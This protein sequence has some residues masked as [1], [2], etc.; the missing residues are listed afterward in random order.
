MKCTQKEIE[1]AIIIIAESLGLKENINYL[2]KNEGIHTT[3]RELIYIMFVQ[4]KEQY[5]EK[6]DDVFNSITLIREYCKELKENGFV[7]FE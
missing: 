4:H 6:D 7:S 3:I 1:N 5:F 2:L